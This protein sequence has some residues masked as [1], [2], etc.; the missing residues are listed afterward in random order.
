MFYGWGVDQRNYWII[1]DYECMVLTHEHVVGR[2]HSLTGAHDRDCGGEMLQ[3]NITL[4]VPTLLP[5]L[6]T[7]PLITPAQAWL[8]K[9]SEFSG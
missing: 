2:L 3:W 1:Y 9:F 4:C 8:M 7:L 5:G 6:I